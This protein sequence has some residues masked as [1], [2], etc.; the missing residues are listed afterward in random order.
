MLIREE[1]GSR[2]QQP[3]PRVFH[4]LL[5]VTAVA[6]WWRRMAWNGKGGKGGHA[7]GGK[8]WQAPGPPAGQPPPGLRQQEDPAHFHGQ[9][10]CSNCGIHCL[11]FQ[12][13]HG[14][15]AKHVGHY[16]GWSIPNKGKYATCVKCG[17]LD[18]NS[19]TYSRAEMWENV[20][21]GGGQDGVGAMHRLCW[22]HRQF[23]YVRGEPPFQT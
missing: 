9:I 23:H 5:R 8:G 7:Q 16:E 6:E 2:V 21:P 17:I 22:Q 13:A 3:S 1:C 14:C 10:T 18:G 11:M 20:C 4:L 19:T 15:C 12:C